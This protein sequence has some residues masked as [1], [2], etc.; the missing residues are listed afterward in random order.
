MPTSDDLLTDIERKSQIAFPLIDI[1]PKEVDQNSKSDPSQT[2]GGP[3]V[4]LDQY[5]LLPLPKK[6]LG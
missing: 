3:H 6:F 5:T 1:D 2:F 4:E